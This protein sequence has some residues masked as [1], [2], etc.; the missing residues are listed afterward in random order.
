MPMNLVMSPDGRFALVSDMGLRQS[1]WSIRTSD[2]VGVSHVEFSNRAPAQPFGENAGPTERRRSDRSNGLYYGLAIAEDRT[3]Y[4]AQGAHDSIAAL[5][6]G[7]DGALTLIGEIRTKPHDFP[8]GLALDRRGHLYVANNASADADPYTLTASVAI[9]DTTTKAELGRFAFVK[10]HGGT[11][12]FP[13]G[14][15]ARPDGSRAYVASERDGAVYVLDTSDPAHPSLAGTLETGAHPVATLLDAEREQ[16]FVSNSLSDTVS[17]IDTRSDQ[18]IGTALLRPAAA[19]DLCGVTPTGLALS[20]DGRTLYAALSDMNAAAVVDVAAAELRGYIPAGWYPTA[21]AATTDGR[22]LIANAK[23]SSI[24]TPSNRPD[25]RRPQHST[26]ALL[27]ALEGNVMGVAV[28]NGEAL[29]RSTEQVLEDN[30]LDRVE[31]GKDNPL[32][33]IDLAAG[34]ITHVAYIVKENR[35]Y[36]QVLGDL[37]QGNGDPSLVL[38]G[39]DVTPNQHALAERFVLLDNLY[40]CG[41]VSGDGWAWSTQGMADAYVARNVPYHYSQRGRK[42]DFEGHNNGYPTGGVPTSG[43][44]GEPLATSPVFKNGAPPV[45]DV[46]NTGRNLWDAAREAGLSLR[47]YGFFLYFSDHV[48]GLPGG[49][50]N[51]PIAPGLQPA[52]HDLAGVTDWDYRRFDMDFPDSDAPEDY[53][54]QTGD[55]RCRFKTT[56][57][58]RYAAASRFAEW[59]RE[60]QMM[61]ERDATGGAVPALMLVRLPADHTVGAS[62]EM[63]T[64]R[65]YV[66][67]NDYALGQIV[68]A[69]S[70]S[71]I[72]PHT[73]I[74]VIEDDAQD[75]VDHVDAH[76]STGFVIS[77]WIKRGSV[78]HRFHNTDS[79][80]RTVELLLG[81]KVLCQYDAIADPIQDWDSSPSNAEA[82]RA[83]K[84]PKELIAEVTPPRE[85]LGASDPR[86]PLILES[87]RM[88]FTHADAAPARKLNEIVW[89]TVK[90][91]A[92]RMPTP[93]G[94]SDNEDDD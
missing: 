63:H 45:P 90:G 12:N 60:F 24:R 30:R 66:A 80:L 39:R 14:I 58:G 32:A 3:V 16:L 92:A 65:S 36:D 62:P 93:R 94:R 17:I 75:G 4:A 29:E 77:P 86:L 1:L 25:P 52:G 56:G 51:Y 82:F 91:P 57:Y 38:F 15:A 47:N 10:S 40:V 27:S 85:S 67:D 53:F 54:K 78:D 87:Q 33:A 64:P 88:D 81:M 44:R 18:I 43:D 73:A 23:G 79:M 34:G 26:I 5:R 6:L 50:D 31:I 19:R 35:T 13:Y 55:A 22:L 37:P 83:I 68:E 28:P 59:N 2:G 46:A 11:S 49:P 76:R 61:L 84:P 20:P 71:P 7:D 89:R 21:L 70:R 9:Y 69:I 72:W 42:F 8:A 41:E 74:F 48:A